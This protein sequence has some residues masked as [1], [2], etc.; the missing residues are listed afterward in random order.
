GRAAGAVL[1]APA[2]TYPPGGKPT[3]RTHPVRV[4]AR[5]AGQA[6]R[7][8]RPPG[9]AHLPVTRNVVRSGLPLL[10]SLCYAGAYT[11][12]RMPPPVMHPLAPLTPGEIRTAVKVVRASGRV[13]LGA[14]F[15]MIALDEPP[16]ELVLRNIDIPRRAFAI[17]YD[18]QANRAWEALADLAAGRV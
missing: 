14:R 17:I 15:S 8:N 1:R 6:G 10:V 9:R 16:K 3:V 13:P 2:G 4:T 7:R 18:D 12:C 5:S 11:A